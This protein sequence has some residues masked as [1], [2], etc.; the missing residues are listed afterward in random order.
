MRF[1]V[2]RISTPRLERSSATRTLNSSFITLLLEGARD[3]DELGGEAGEGRLELG[4]EAH[5]AV[6]FRRVVAGADQRDLE[7]AGEL[8]GALVELA[9]HEGVAA[10]PRRVLEQI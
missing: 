1:D 9:G 5:G 3:V 6:H 2:L 4:G 7:L 10:D 8:A